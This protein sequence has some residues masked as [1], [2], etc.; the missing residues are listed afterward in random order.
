[1]KKKTIYNI[2]GI[3]VPILLVA[4]IVLAITYGWYVKRQQTADINATT[5][6]VAIEYT[7]DD[8]T[9]KN[10]V[11]YNVKHIA[12]FD[13]DSTDVNKIELKYLPTMAVK[14]ELKLTNKSSNDVSYKITFESTKE[15]VSETVGGNTVKKSIAYMDCLFYDITNIPSSVTTVNGIKA[16]SQEGVTYTNTP[17]STTNKAEYDSSALTTPLV[18]APESET[19]V[20]LVM[21]IYGVQEQ[22]NALNDDFLY[23]YETENEVVTKK[24]RR[25]QFSLTIESIPIGEVEVV[26]NGTNNNSG[27]D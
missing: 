15:F 21:Y 8:D 24:L 1:M 25:Y 12:F 27:N 23:S 11:D 16:L 22:D 20:T 2:L 10:V 13:V 26:E 19:P 17:S 14:L 4:S 6:N 7:F 9:T 5:K 3:A 18:L